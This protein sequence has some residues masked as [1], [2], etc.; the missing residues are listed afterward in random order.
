MPFGG[1]KDF[2]DCVSKNQDKDNPQAFCASIQ[3]K[4]EG[5]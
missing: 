2:K 4:A 3:K 5:K 1:F